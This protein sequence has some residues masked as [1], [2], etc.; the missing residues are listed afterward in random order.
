MRSIIGE[1]PE[2]LKDRFC[3]FT[4][5][6]LF[7]ILPKKVSRMF[8]ELS[9]YFLFLNLRNCSD[10]PV[11]DM[12]KLNRL[13]NRNYNKDFVALPNHTLN[14]FW[15]DNYLNREI[16]LH[17]GRVT[18]REALVNDDIMKKNLGTLANELISNLPTAIKYKLDLKDRKKEIQFRHKLI[19][20]FNN[21]V[22]FS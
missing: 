8:V 7:L 20:L 18:I 15:P 12:N 5:L 6:A 4:T 21:E 10:G 16:D 2:S 22:A 14:W 19:N 3:K 11:V 13:L 17:T 9:V 1:R